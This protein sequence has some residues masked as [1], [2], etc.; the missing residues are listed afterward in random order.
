MSIATQNL[1]AVGLDVEQG[2]SIADLIARAQLA[3]G[4]WKRVSWRAR[5]RMLKKL[6]HQVVEHA[7]A[8]AGLC[9]SENRT[10]DEALV[11]EVLPLAEAVRFAERV[12]SR[13]LRT[14]RWGGRLRPLWLW[15]TSL[16]IEREPFGLVLV[17]GP[18][19]YPLFLPGV[20]LVQAIAA[21]NAVVVKPAPGCTQ[22][23]SMLKAL[24]VA[25]GIDGDLIAVLPESIESVNDAIRAGI[26]KVFFTGSTGSGR[27]VIALTARSGHSMVAELSGNDAVFVCEDADVGMAAR[28]L[29]FGL[30]FNG[31]ETCVA[32]RRVFVDKSR[33]SALLAALVEQCRLLESVKLNE[34]QAAT[35]QSAIED[36][37]ESGGAV[38]AGGLD[39]NLNTCR[40]VVIAEPGLSSKL[41]RQAVWGPVLAVLGVGPMDEA[42]EINELCPY[43]LGAVVFGNKQARELA[44][45][46]HAGVVVVNDLIVPHADPRLPFEGRGASGFGVTRGAEGLLE[47]TRPKAMSFRSGKLRPHYDP[48][49]A[50]QGE[51]FL[52]YMK[53]THGGGIVSRLGCFF[54]ASKLALRL[55][56]EGKKK[57]K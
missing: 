57:S 4:A 51:L 54:R 27:E 23:I 38:V 13:M 3:Q 43:A 46:I 22:V 45:R 39:L 21:G 17:V 6:R 26:D 42:L 19:N 41:I 1:P 31:S 10:T 56:R 11:S 28:A 14:L 20:Q 16:E 37:V 29:A 32:P 47:M 52:N 25:A 34:G 44:A 33:K 40:P 7:Q 35:L 48:P 18:G 36:A 8:L 30:R 2:E 55:L 15:G 5:R 12:G 24:I 9:A 53:A 50:L 49:S